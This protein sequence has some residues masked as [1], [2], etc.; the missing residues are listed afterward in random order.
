MRLFSEKPPS[1]VH[2]RSGRQEI[3]SWKMMA[4]VIPGCIRPFP[5]A[6]TRA[7]VGCFPVRLF[8]Q[9]LWL[10]ADSVNAALSRPAWLS[11]G[12][13]ECRDTR[14]GTQRVLRKRQASAR[15]ASQGAENKWNETILTRT[16][17]M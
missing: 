10:K 12:A 16:V 5:L 7:V 4:P 3:L 17:T 6:S 15:P 8:R 13:A 9:F 14:A 2:P 1:L 11:T